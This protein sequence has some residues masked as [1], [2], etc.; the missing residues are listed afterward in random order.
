MLSLARP[1]HFY[2]FFLTQSIGAGIGMG[3]MFVPA[4]SVTAH[5]FRKKRSLAMG[6]VIA[7]LCLSRGRDGR[8]NVSSQGPA[9]EDVYT[10]SCSI[11]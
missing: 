4:I 7:G 9:W 3:L 2:Q 1:H 11:T 8:L 6:L 5:Y 10:L